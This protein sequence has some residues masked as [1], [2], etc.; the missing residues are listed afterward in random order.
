MVC[1]SVV[2]LFRALYGSL[3]FVFLGCL[4]CCRTIN[5]CNLGFTAPNYLHQ[6]VRT[7]APLTNHWSENKTVTKQIAECLLGSSAC[8][9][10]HWGSKCQMW[11]W[12]PLLQIA[13]FLSIVAYALRP[14]PDSHQRIIE[15]FQR[16]REQLGLQAN[17]SI[18]REPT[19][20]QWKIIGEDSTVLHC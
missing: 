9:P 12:L 18:M 10:G 5:Q 7:P 1:L 8:H 16:S 13:P 4:F 14:S 3:L 2:Q 15:H 11:S 17:K 19:W 20:L 6:D